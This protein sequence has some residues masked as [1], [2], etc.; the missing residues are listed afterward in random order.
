MESKHGVDRNRALRGLKS[1]RLVQKEKLA[2]KGRLHE[3]GE[4]VMFRLQRARSV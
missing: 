1:K 4:V 2:D 3:A